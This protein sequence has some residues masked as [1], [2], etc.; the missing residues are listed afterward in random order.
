[1]RRPMYAAAFRSMR[2][3][4]LGVCAILLL[5]Y[6]P[7]PAQDKEAALS[8]VK[9]GRTPPLMNGLNLIAEGAGFYKEEH[10]KVTTVAS[11]GPVDAR[12]IC[13]SG[14]GDICPVGMEPLV[15]PSATGVQLKMF[16]ARIS[17]FGY[18]IGVPADSRIK[19]PA[20][21][22]S[23]A[24]TFGSTRCILYGLL[25]DPIWWSRVGR[26]RWQAHKSAR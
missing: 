17:K 8:V 12:R 13:S 22:D 24:P 25:L 4:G 15:A 19:T 9:D 10:L 20:D 7:A 16:L 21:L 3:A 18:V 6:G 1:M 14:E 26:G 2:N 23:D 5:V 11:D